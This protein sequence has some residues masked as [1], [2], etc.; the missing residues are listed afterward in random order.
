M[1]LVFYY[2]TKAKK[3]AAFSQKILQKM[4]FSLTGVSKRV[5]KAKA[6]C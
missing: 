1:Q 3:M 4:V 5:E 6:N 2:T